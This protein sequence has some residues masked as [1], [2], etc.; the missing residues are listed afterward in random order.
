MDGRE[1]S[2]SGRGSECGDGSISIAE[3]VANLL[4]LAPPSHLLPLDALPGGLPDL[5]PV[6]HPGKIVH[7]F[8][9]PLGQLKLI[10]VCR[11]VAVPSLAY[12]VAA[13]LSLVLL[14]ARG[15]PAVVNGTRPAV[16]A[17]RGTR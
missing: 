17:A 15:V 9:I 6:L 10:I 3:V 2:S 14:T 16:G 4:L 7:Y 5:F 13:G 1:G 12:R 11:C 8:F